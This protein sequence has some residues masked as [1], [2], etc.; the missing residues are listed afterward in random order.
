MF[1]LWFLG[2]LGVIVL[3]QWY[4]FRIPDGKPY[5]GNLDAAIDVTLE[6]TAVSNSH[7]TRYA[8]AFRTGPEPVIL[9]SV[10]SKVRCIAGTSATLRVLLYEDGENGPAG[11]NLID[12]WPVQTFSGANFGDVNLTRSAKQ[13]YVLLPNRTYWIAIYDNNTAGETSAE[14]ARTTDNRL[15]QPSMPGAS[16][17]STANF[18]VS[19]SRGTSW[20]PGESGAPG[21][22]RIYVSTF[23]S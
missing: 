13:K 10:V 4:L 22:F 14:W 18:F 15:D 5:V 12:A 9:E 20:T 11:P 8:S 16:I 17:P 23:N 2:I 6:G 1:W 19:G 7:F 3:L 21:M